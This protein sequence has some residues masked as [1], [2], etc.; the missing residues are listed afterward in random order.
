LA[1]DSIGG[2]QV[3]IGGQGT[4]DELRHWS[5]VLARYGM[6]GTATGALGVLGPI[7]MSYGQTISTVRY[8]SLLLSD[9]V[10]DMLVE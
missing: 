8:L 10:A 3:L 2:V 6:P 9:L 1:A 4:W 7:R 5:I